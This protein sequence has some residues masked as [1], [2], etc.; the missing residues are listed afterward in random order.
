MREAL[1]CLGGFFAGVGVTT[2]IASE[3]A[4]LKRKNVA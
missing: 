2:L 1:F 4:R 3:M